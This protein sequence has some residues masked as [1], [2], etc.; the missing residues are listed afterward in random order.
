MAKAARGSIRDRVIYAGVWLACFAPA[1]WLAA[2]LFVLDDLGA[3]PIEA[4]IR[5]LGVWG[6]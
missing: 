6:F 1:V 2:R 3:N 5:Q 4:L